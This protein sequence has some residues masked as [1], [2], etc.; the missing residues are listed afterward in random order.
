[1]TRNTPVVVG[2]VLRGSDGS[3]LV[4]KLRFENN[5]LSISLAR[6]HSLQPSLLRPTDMSQQLLR[7]FTVTWMK[8]S[9]TAMNIG[10]RQDAPK[11]CNTA[12]STKNAGTSLTIS[13]T[14]P[15]QRDEPS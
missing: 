3:W 13:I 15:L 9:H 14:S 6:S 12:V 7:I 10:I 1:M 5:L 11:L 8:L 2:Y 4:V